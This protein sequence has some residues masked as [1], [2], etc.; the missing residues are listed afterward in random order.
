MK[1]SFDFIRYP[2]LIITTRRI[3]IHHSITTPPAV[4]ITTPANGSALRG[5]IDMY[6]RPTTIL[7]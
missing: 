3:R 2:P 6:I 4:S 1:H 5:I 7:N